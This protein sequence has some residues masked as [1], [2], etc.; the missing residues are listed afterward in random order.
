MGTAKDNIPVTIITDNMAGH[1]MQKGKIDCVIVGATGLPPTAMWPIRSEPIRLR[2][3][4]KKRSAFF[5]AAPI[6]TLDLS[7]PD[8]SLIP[9]EESKFRDEPRP[10]SGLLRVRQ[11]TMKDAYSFDLDQA[12]LD[13]S[14]EDQRRAYERIFSRCG[15]DFVR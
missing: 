10:K 2:F 6:S 3:W 7:L 11:F 9:I 1:F 4:P 12:G 5:V 8:G 13:R 14:Y 15:L